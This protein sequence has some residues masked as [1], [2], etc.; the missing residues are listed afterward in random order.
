MSDAKLTEVQAYI[1]DYIREQGGGGRAGLDASSNFVD[2]GLL[3]SFA[4]LSLIM[5]LESEFAVK[6]QP[7]ELADP[8]M[9]TVGVL[10]QAVL[11]KSA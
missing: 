4:I 9:R 7:H 10:A 6:F 3:D 2:S 11:D 1:L 8:A 5:S